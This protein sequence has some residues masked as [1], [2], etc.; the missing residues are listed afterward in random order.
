[1]EQ[2]F[3]THASIV[4]TC[5]SLGLTVRPTPANDRRAYEATPAEGKRVRVY[6]TTSYEGG[7]LGLPRVASQSRDT[8][9]RTLSEIHYLVT[10]P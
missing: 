4:R 3:M 8:H 2:T 9:A 5:T 10:T 6:W 7:L 1:M